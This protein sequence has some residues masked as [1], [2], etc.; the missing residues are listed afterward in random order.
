M[1]KASRKAM[2]QEFVIMT[3]R[4]WKLRRH[5]KTSSERRSTRRNNAKY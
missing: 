2:E 1:R 3:R 4:R 5:S